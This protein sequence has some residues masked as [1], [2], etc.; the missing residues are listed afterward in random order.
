M[1]FNDMNIHLKKLEKKNPAN[2]TQRKQKDSISGPRDFFVG[3][4]IT[5]SIS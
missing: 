3:M 2:Q 5:D 4:L 1:E